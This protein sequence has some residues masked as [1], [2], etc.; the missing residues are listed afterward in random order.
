MAAGSR[1]YLAA[2][3]SLVWRGTVLVTRPFDPIQELTS[4]GRV[5]LSN[6]LLAAPNIV[7]FLIPGLIVLV[8]GGFTIIGGLMNPSMFTDPSALTGLFTGSLIF[9]FCLAGLL[10]IIL[11]LVATGALYAGCG[12]ALAGRPVDLAS[13]MANGLKHAGSVFVYG[14][15]IAVVVIAAELVV[16]LLGIISHG[17]L[18]F[19]AAIVLFFASIYAGFLLVYGFA[20]MIVGGRGPIDAMKESAG[21]ARANMS[22]TLML[23]LAFIVLF[24]ASWIV[25]A[26]LGLIPVLGLLIALAISGLN[27]AFMAIFSV[28]FYT[29]LS[30]KA[31]PTVVS[32]PP[33]MPS[34]PST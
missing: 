26:I 21:L 14:L 30:G 3:S 13:M 10:F 31:A 20:S 32:A 27:A 33:S 6:L 22:T 17:I 23:I 1:R 29:L 19:L 5:L 8:F 12:D 11:S 2:S 7:A 9:G 25:S 15:I 16:F 28:R 18:G 4:A 24:I 34:P